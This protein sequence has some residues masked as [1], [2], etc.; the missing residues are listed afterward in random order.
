MDALREL[1][2]SEPKASVAL[3]ARSPQV[4]DLRSSGL[5]KAS[6]FERGMVGR[7][8]EVREHIG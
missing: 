8:E 6:F 3:L 1:E 2:E 7:E 4:A 5:D